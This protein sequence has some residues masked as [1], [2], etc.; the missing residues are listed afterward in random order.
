MGFG[1][2][3]PTIN[4]RPLDAMDI[5]PSVAAYC[6]CH[7]SRFQRIAARNAPIA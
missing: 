1:I 7:F 5:G 4:I 2:D 6:L 3:V